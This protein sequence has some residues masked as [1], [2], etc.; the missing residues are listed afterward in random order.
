MPLKKLL[1]CLRHVQSDAAK[2]PPQA[3]DES[4][5]SLPQP[6][7]RSKQLPEATAV[8]PARLYRFLS[9]QLTLEDIRHV[10]FILSIDF[11]N[12]GGLGQQAKLR[13][14]IA[15]C[16]AQHQIN[17]LVATLQSL[18][19]NLAWQELSTLPEPEVEQPVDA[20]QAIS[21]GVWVTALTNHF[22]L[23]ELQT[24]CF[25]LAVDFDELS[26]TTK[27]DKAKSLAAFM[28]DTGRLLELAT[29]IKS[30]RQNV[31]LPDFLS[32]KQ[33]L[34]VMRREP[35]PQEIREHQRALNVSNLLSTNFA[36]IELW[37]LVFDLGLAAEEFPMQNRRAFV[38]ELMQYLRR[39]KMIPELVVLSAQKRPDLDWRAAWDEELPPQVAFF[40]AGYNTAAIRQL[41]FNAFADDVAL[42][43]FC[44]QH[45]P[46]AVYSFG[47]GM[48]FREK[49]QA[50]LEYGRARQQFAL[51][52]THMAATYPDQYAMYG[53][54]HQET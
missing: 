14:L 41:A 27:S 46:D 39:R 11:E 38:R 35:S 28:I 22:N 40:H 47:S 34:P 19:P 52:L 45:M 50:W 31:V 7:P 10:A 9:D 21:E 24:L 48:S 16:K 42:T 20:P 54:Y 26:G 17:K 15:W 1:S 51:F 5:V 25:E 44:R 29:A 30:R 43:Q 13:E 32:N 6:T 49:V 23:H 2:R 4:A 36:K 12:L 3:V 37:E 33:P 53:P 8:D 18:F